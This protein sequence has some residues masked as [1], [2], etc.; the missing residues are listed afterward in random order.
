MAYF[1]LLSDHLQNSYSV[2]PHRLRDWI[3]LAG[4]GGG[5]RVHLRANKQFA[6]IVLYRQT[7]RRLLALF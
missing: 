7:K 4:G 1:W 3:T 5:R 2:K 6:N